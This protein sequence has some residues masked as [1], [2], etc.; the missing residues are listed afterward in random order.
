[1]EFKILLTALPISIVILL[2]AISFGRMLLKHL[3]IKASDDLEC[4][5]FATGLGLGVLAY[6]VLAVGLA[7]ILYAW[8]LVTLLLILAVA[9]IKEMGAFIRIIY[10]QLRMSGKK[11]SALYVL[12]LIAVVL[13][14]G[15]VLIS[16]LAPPAFSDWDGLAYHLAVPKMYLKAHKIYYIPFISHSNFPFLIEML[17]T[18]GL[19][20]GDI[21]VAKLFHFAMYITTAVGIFSLGRK[22]INSVAG[23]V[24]VLVFM[25]VPLCIWEAG[26][27]YS[28]LSTA[29][30]V[31][32]A[33]YCVV[34]WEAKFERGW[35]ILG[36]I[37][38]GFALGTKVLAVVPVLALCLWV[39]V[40]A[41]RMKGISEGIKSASILGAV[42]LLIAAPWYIKTF[43]YT[44]NPVY[45][46]LYN[47]FGGKYWSAEAAQSYRQAQLEFGMGR[48]LLDFVLLP[49]N[50]TMHGSKFYDKGAPVLLGI[51]GP[52]F[53]G[54]LGVQ[55]FQRNIS[56]VAIKLQLVAGAFI[57]AWFF[58]MQSARYMMGI[59]PLLSIAVGAAV[60]KANT[61]WKITRHIVNMFVAG[62]ILVGLYPAAVMGYWCG[63]VVFGLEPFEEYLS[64]SLDVYDA[65]NFINTSTPRNSKIILYDE[66]RGFYLDR[67]YIWGNPGHHE[68]IPYR[69][70]K[71]GDQLVDWLRSQGFT[72][73]LINWRFSSL[74]SKASYQKLILQAIGSGRLAE[75]FSSNGVS[76]YEIK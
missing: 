24:G 50:I 32:L 34:N 17:Y 23:F 57:I 27:A 36:G 2:I 49:W 31:L 19:A 54:I 5:I 60:A 59:L 40:S 13:M 67:T 28:D 15:F 75:A 69:T 44:G 62:C 30:Y 12:I 26:I 66:V 51:I 41:C 48:G 56:K 64:R 33:T 9:S 11:I 4:S 6:L 39:F 14:G 58:L 37:M 76:V 72:H 22:Y 45:P 3:G 55:V 47:I 18:I 35:L 53:L 1:M 70:F 16:A 38:G 7:N 42:L 74:G 61:D 46:F 73:A 43:I 65:E 20:L 52:A 63:P 68:M 29:L 10:N 25:S 8:V 71:T 21:G